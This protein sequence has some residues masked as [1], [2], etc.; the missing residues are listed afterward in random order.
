MFATIA[1]FPYDCRV[2]NVPSKVTEGNPPN[3]A[4]FVPVRS[5]RLGV[6]EVSMI[7]L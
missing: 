3:G 6:F 4:K 1:V 2:S 7:A 5:S